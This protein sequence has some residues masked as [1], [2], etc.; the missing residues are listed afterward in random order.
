M[1]FVASLHFAVILI[2]VSR[3]SKLW[4]AVGIPFERAVLYHVI[5]GHLAFTAVFTHCILFVAYWVWT[6][7]WKHAW[8]TSTSQVNEQYGYVDVPM[9]WAA[10]LCAV[11]M[12][13]TSINYVR[14]RWYSLFKASHWLFIGVFLFGA[15]HWSSNASY[16]AMGLT[17]YTMHVMSRLSSWKRWRYW[18]RWWN[19]AT[20]DT[21]PTSLVNICTIDNY[22][23]LVL[24]NP[25]S[26]EPA[27]GGS[28]VYIS[29]PGALGTDE[30]HAMTVALRGAPPSFSPEKNRASSPQEDVFTLYVKALGPWTKALRSVAKGAEASRFRDAACDPSSMLVD[31][32]GFYT[33]VTS[34]NTMLHEGAGRIVVVAGGSGVT[35]LMGF[36][37]DWCVAAST[38]VSVPEV[39][40]VWS[41][42]SMKEMEL[43]G[44]SLPSLLAS[45][46]RKKD[47][48]FTMSLYCTGKACAPGP[49]TVTWPL[50][51][52]HYSGSSQEHVLGKTPVASSLN[53]SVRVVIASAAGFGGYVLGQYELDRRQ[54]QGFHAGGVLLTLI[55]VCIISALLVYDWVTGLIQMCLPKR[56]TYSGM[57]GTSHVDESK[58]DTESA[59]ASNNSA[60]YQAR[61]SRGRVPANELFSQ[62]AVLAHK[63]GLS[64]V[65]VL[66]S[67]PHALV[68]SVL[69]QSRAVDWKLFDTEEF[70]FE[71]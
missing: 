40:L 46:G 57:G 44:E 28:F 49:L 8:V 33:H 6:D 31:V 48:H 51:N 12:W 71:F 24:R 67:G 34:F 14:R 16:F 20:R 27:R 15:L 62:E 9:G 23:R 3:D 58:T 56:A 7:G 63:K 60:T 5:A 26:H 4:S 69:T 42:R 36:I 30:A 2:P 22:T 19:P 61:V 18:N 50:D 37:Q 17:L 1:G 32:D 47:S 65:K 59:W 10:A 64:V 45:A 68:D 25:K 55:V 53:H 13:I 35:S 39:H 29:A 11:P 52:T 54:A 41:C 21:T 38:G 70:S 43:V 66:T